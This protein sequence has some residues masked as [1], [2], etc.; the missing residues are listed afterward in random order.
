MCG[1]ERRKSGSTYV[2]TRH[3]FE[4]LLNLV[5]PSASLPYWDWAVDVAPDS[6]VWQDD[7]MGGDGSDADAKAVIDS[8]FR[9]GRWEPTVFD[10]S[11][12][13]RTA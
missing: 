6:D 4:Q 1:L 12:A 10:Y 13:Q 2:F 5:D 7:F 8:P 3:L 11:D 9:K